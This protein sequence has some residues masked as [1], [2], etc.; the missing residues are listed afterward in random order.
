MKTEEVK[1][2][3][4]DLEAA[5]NELHASGKMPPLEDVLKAVAEAREKYSDKIKAARNEPEHAGIDALGK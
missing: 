2:R 5:A 1:I 4:S 3:P